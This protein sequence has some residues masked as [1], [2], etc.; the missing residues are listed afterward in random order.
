MALTGALLGL[1]AIT[2][3]GGTARVVLG[4]AAF[5]LVTGSAVAVTAAV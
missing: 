2:G 4:A 1:A 5:L 3:E